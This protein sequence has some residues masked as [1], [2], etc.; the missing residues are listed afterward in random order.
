MD[1]EKSLLARGTVD[2]Y[3]ILHDILK[4]WLP[5]VLIALSAGMLMHV[6]L[7]TRY[8]PVYTTKT[9]M[10]VT[11]PGT[12]SSA[13]ENLYSASDTAARFTQLLNSSIL[14]KKV[15]E[16]IGLP[17]FHGSAEAKNQSRT[18]LLIVTVTAES[19]SVS[20][21]EMKS[22]LENYKIVSGQLMEDVT[23]TIL[24]APRVPTYP[25]NDLRTRRR[26]IQA[27]AIAGFLAAFIIGL[28]SWLRDT[29]RSNKDV[30]S[31]LDARHLGTI[32]HER[33][34]R[35]LLA[36]IRRPKKSILINDHVTSFR[37]VETI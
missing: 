3:S 8:R 4:Q 25:S 35:T 27:T 6:F 29:I 28:F 31:K 5:I 20:F 15:A 18:N 16:E 13:Y 36:M 22:I 30:E 33:K 10:V 19:P 9:T 32:H 24:E 14:Q 1:N 2:Y 26:D 21:R 34:Y 12:S 7:V 17:Y 23:L 37:Y 11:R